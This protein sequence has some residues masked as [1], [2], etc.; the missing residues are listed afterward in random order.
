MAKVKKILCVCG[1]RPQILK[2]AIFVTQAIRAG[3]DVKTV[4]TGQHWDY[5]L[6]GAFLKELDIP[7]PEYVL[8]VGDK[9]FGER[10]GRMVTGVT[11][12][13]R[14][15]APDVVI[16]YGDCDTTLAATLAARRVGVR[17]GH[18]EAGLR[19]GD[20]GMPEEQNRIVVDELSDYCFC[21]STMAGGNLASEGVRGTIHVTGDIVK[22][23]ME[24]FIEKSR[25]SPVLA[26]LE[27]VEQSYYY[28]TIHRAENTADKDRLKGILWALGKLD[29]VVVFPIHPRTEKKVKEWGLGKMLKAGNIRVIPPVGY[30]ESLRLQESACKVITDSGTMQKE[31]FIL[32]VPCVTLRNSTEYPETTYGNWNILCPDVAMV[33]RAVVQ[34]PSRAHYRGM[35]GDGAAVLKILE[36]LK[37][38]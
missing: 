28:A 27:V 9:G 22:D 18:I 23:L 14:D 21:T 10:L 5:R 25:E 17:V 31:A 1:T 8:K 32:G 15:Y 19:S 20:M 4:W 26:D 3:F 24:L 29:K 30:L 7:R 16:V 13:I 34:A 12:V 36:V 33:E 6:F 11:G 38:C 35:F 2:H 37:E